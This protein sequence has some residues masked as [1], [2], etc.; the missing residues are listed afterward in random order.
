MKS[1]RFLEKPNL[2][3]YDV[4][5]AVVSAEYPQIIS[6]LK[7]NGITPVTVEKCGTVIE[8]VSEHADMLFSY[9]GNGKYLCE[10]SQIELTHELYSHGF[11][12]LEKFELKREYPFDIPLNHVVIGNNLICKASDTPELVKNNFQVINVKQGYAKCSCAVVDE[13]S[14]ITDDESVFNVLSES[15]LDVLLVRKGPV[16]LKGL[17][18]GFIGGCCGKIAKDTL[19]FCGDISAHSD[20]SQI[21]AFLTERKVYPLSLTKGELTDIGS[22][23]PVTELI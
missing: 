2:P 23:I 12:C 20:Y 5:H 4:L 21:K 15:D 10:K 3:S 8:P 22:I 17:D 6:A 16:R 19:A 7:Q 14:I 13:N 11:Q 1:Y 9:I 18:Y